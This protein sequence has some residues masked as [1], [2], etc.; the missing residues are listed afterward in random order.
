M[1][2]RKTSEERIRRFSELNDV[3]AEELQQPIPRRTADVDEDGNIVWGAP[4]SEK[5]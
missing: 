2:E 4:R 3:I 5:G 1:G